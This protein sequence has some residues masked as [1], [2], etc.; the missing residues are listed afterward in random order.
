MKFQGK[1]KEIGQLFLTSENR[2][3]TLHVHT[4][5]IQ[6]GAFYTHGANLKQ[7]GR[8]ENEACVQIDGR[9]GIMRDSKKTEFTNSYKGQENDDQR[10][11][12]TMHIE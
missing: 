12:R 3:E 7:E 8:K 11:E 1:Q 6:R 9:T 2:D 4:A 10:K 5:E